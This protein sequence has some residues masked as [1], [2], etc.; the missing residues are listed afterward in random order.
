MQGGVWSRGWAGGLGVLVLIQHRRLSRNLGPLAR[1]GICSAW[2]WV[3]LG[4]PWMGG[5][6]ASEETWKYKYFE[7]ASLKQTL[8]AAVSAESPSPQGWKD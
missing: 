6:C 5:A 7:A 1:P 2:G 8:G 3:C 4:W